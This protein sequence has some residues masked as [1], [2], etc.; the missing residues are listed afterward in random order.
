MEYQR[1]DEYGRVIRYQGTEIGRRWCGPGE[2]RTAP[3]RI[4][5][6]HGAVGSNL[7][8]PEG[9]KV[10]SAETGAWISIKPEWLTAIIGWVEE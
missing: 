8:Y 1:S 10:W 6:A 3:G 2:T 5:V 9:V 7:G 4:A